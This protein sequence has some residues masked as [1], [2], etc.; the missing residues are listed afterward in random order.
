[1]EYSA[2]M[3]SHMYWFAETRI[4]ANHVLK[5]LS[6]NE[7][8]DL[9]INQNIYQMNNT[10]R[11]SRNFSTIYNRIE[12]MPHDLVYAIVNA[13]ISTA[14]LLVLISMMKTDRLFFEFVY[15]VFR[16][17]I[18]L[19]EKCIELRNIVSFFH[20]KSTQSEIVE[21]WSDSTKNK[22]K[23]VYIRSL[24]EAGLIKSV[25]NREII[26]P[27][28]DYKMRKQFEENDMMTYLNA[29]TGEN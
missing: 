26:I 14:K 1:M 12:C 3:M 21:S 8:R 18:L 9:A 17:R 27:L 10:S 22:L 11:I 13:D 29:I 20:I 25:N 5:E 28:V 16:E 6:K 23:R 2:G 4:T 7:I 15:E 19:G 24:Y